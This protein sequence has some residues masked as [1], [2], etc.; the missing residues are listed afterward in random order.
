MD[1]SDVREHRAYGESRSA[2]RP[3]VKLAWAVDIEVIDEGQSSRRGCGRTRGIGLGGAFVESDL[4]LRPG[5]LVQLWLHPPALS[6]HGPS[7]TPMLPIRARVRWVVAA[8]P[9]PVAAG[10]GVQ[11]CALNAEA[12]AQ[13]HRYFSGAQAGI[14][15]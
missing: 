5:D 9:D 8:E 15:G 4:E 3:P 10:F 14:G 13:L 12:E 7:T 1:E 6:T 2:F 11:F